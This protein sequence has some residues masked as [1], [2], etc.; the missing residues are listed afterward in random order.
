MHTIIQ[1]HHRH[2]P[3]FF[4]FIIKRKDLITYYHLSTNE[5]KDFLT[6]KLIYIYICI[7][8]IHIYTY[9]YKYI[10]CI[11]VQCKN[12]ALQILTKKLHSKQQWKNLNILYI[13][14]YKCLIFEMN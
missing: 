1:M 12:N 2:I 10:S 8:N 13:Y 6:L 4:F 11:I 5:N 9:T 3:D 14:V 7:Y